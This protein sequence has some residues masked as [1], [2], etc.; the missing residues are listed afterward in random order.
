[1]SV[2]GSGV[3]QVQQLVDRLTIPGL[4]EWSG[5]VALL[6]L[7]M[8]ALTWLLMPFSVFGLK[9]RLEILE[10]HLD[11]IHSELRALGMRLADLPRPG[12]GVAGDY[13]EV[14]VPR[15]EPPPAPRPTPPVPPPAARPEPR[16][17]W[18]NSAGR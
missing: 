12:P 15:R 16:L 5:L 1:M 14:P 3:E 9:S 17:D 13:L 10:A 7:A 8:V 18:P 4:P 2:R 11:E 6:V